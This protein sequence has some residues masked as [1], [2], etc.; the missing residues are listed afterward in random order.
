MQFVLKVEDTFSI[1]KRGVLLSPWLPLNFF[2]GKKLPELV[3]LRLPDGSRKEVGATFTIPCQSPQPK[4]CTI[5]CIL[6]NIE[7]A[8]V[9][10]G[11]EVWAEINCDQ[12]Y[13]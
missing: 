7:K 13:L 9:P 3:E 11:S 10:I 4:E 12:K 2:D 5:V 1:A 6:P 8:S